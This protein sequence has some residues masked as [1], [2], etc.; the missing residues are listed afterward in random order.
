MDEPSATLTPREVAHLFEIVR[1]LKSH[2]IGVIY[3]SHRLDEIFALCDRVMVMRDGSHVGSKP[4]AE[5][6]RS[7]MI[8]M[9][10]GRK[11]ENEFPKDRRRKVGRER[12]KV[13]NLRRGHRVKDV[14]FVARAGEV[15]GFTGL[16]GAGR[17]E[18]MRLIFGADAAE[19]GEIE[20]DGKPLQIRN[21]RAAIRARIGLLTEDRKGQGLV[22]TQSLRSNFGLPNLPNLSRYGLVDQ[23]KERREFGGYIQSLQ[24]KTPHQEETAKNL[25]GGNQQKVVL[26]KWL[27]RDCD[28]LI[29]D[30]PTRGIDVSTKYEIY[31]LINR[32]AAEGKAIII[33]S[34]ELPE[35]LGISDRVLVMHEGQITGEIT[36]V[37]SATQ[38]QIMQLAVR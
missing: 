34:S 2:G 22:L 17:T 29:F 37:D 26:A 20:L 15:L 18:T 7:A 3:I 6:N 27:E 32:L 25:S 31:L 1:E 24:I 10:V 5:I 4:I 16:V 38:E 21:P 8:E 11:L 33:V 28:V 13:R 19:S 36:D 23:G 35:V 30:E 12:L 14:S 9:M